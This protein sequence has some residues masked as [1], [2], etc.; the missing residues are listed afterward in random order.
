MRACGVPFEEL[1]A[2]A[3]RHRWPAF[4]IGDDV[5]ALYQADGGI[6]AAARGTA[7]LQRAARAYGAHLHGESP[8]TAIDD[9]GGELRVTA[10][11]EIYRARKLVIAAGPWTSRALS[12]LDT[13]IS[14][15]VT[16]EQVTYFAPPDS[17]PFAVGRF[18]VWIWMDDPNFYGFPAFAGA[19]VK[20]AQDAG[21]EVVDPDTRGFDP[22]PAISSRVRTFLQEHLPSL[23]AYEGRTKTCLYTL[24]PDRD[25]VLD[26]IAG[27]PDICV[28]VG[29]GHAFKFASVLGRMLAEIALDDAPC[30]AEFSFE[31]S[32]L[33]ESAPPKTYMV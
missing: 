8:V 2:H 17:E 30:S 18:P 23:V 4:Q 32:I 16:K 19:G 10:G 24:T 22:D 11:G 6:V 3:I 26:R 1:D 29:A 12:M 28:A 25:F 21:G 9:C 31:R 27:H 15:E 13:A 7:A 14:L 20:V 5:H 33:H